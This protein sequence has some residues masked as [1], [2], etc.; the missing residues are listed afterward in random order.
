MVDVV[1]KIEIFLFIAFWVIQS[2]VVVP[3]LK[4]VKKIYWFDW[5]ASGPHQINNLIEYK[6]VCIKEYL[7]LTWYKLQVFIL[8]FFTLNLFIIYLLVT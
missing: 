3:K 8:I 5:V 4:G 7:P 2:L 1:V 6:K